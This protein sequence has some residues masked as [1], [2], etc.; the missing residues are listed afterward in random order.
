MTLQNVID[1][2][3]NL[4]ADERAELV[5]AIGATLTAVRHPHISRISGVCGGRAVIKGT[6]VPVKVL[7]GYHH[8]GQSPAEILAGYPN[9]NMAQFYDALSYYYDHKAEIDAEI[10]ADKPENFM[11]RFNL[12]MN[13]DG[14]LTQNAEA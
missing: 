5:D 8:V 9:V 12:S 6:R 13:E 10:D 3:K 4:T 14:V 1:Q 2:A 7:V 11:Q